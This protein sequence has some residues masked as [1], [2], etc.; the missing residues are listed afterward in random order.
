MDFLS[1]LTCT[2]VQVYTLDTYVRLGLDDEWISSWNS[3]S[4]KA[5]AIAFRSSR[6]TI[7]SAPAA[8]PED[9][10]TTGPA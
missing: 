3:N 8:L 9:R 6:T 7:T 1:S 4:L 10:P 5:G 2:S